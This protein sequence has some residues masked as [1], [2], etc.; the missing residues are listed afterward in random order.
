MEEG[1]DQQILEASFKNKPLISGFLN[2]I[3]NASKDEASAQPICP[4]MIA[5]L[6]LFA[7]RPDYKQLVHE[8]GKA[9]KFVAELNALKH[10]DYASGS[11]EFKDYTS[12]YL[13]EIFSPDSH[14][15]H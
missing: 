2:D 6:S 10:T 14:N 3:F 1:W 5:T 11:K 8:L 15:G 12:Q 13:R 4:V 9:L 7:L